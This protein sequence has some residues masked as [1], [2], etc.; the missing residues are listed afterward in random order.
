MQTVLLISPVTLGDEVQIRQIHDS[1]PA[2]AIAQSG[3]VENLQAF[4]GSGFY[5]L[6]LAFAAGDFQEQ[7]RTFVSLPEVQTFFDALRP[8]VQSLPFP[9]DETAD[10]LLAS[11][12]TYWEQGLQS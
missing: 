1:L 3:S 6:Q 5:A 12:V 7:F 4:V 9:E 8:Y 11:P 10:L 2:E